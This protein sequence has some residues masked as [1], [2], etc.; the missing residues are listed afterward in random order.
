MGD[1]TALSELIKTQQPKIRTMLYYLKKDENDLNDLVQNV[2]IK[3]NTKIYQLKNPKYFRTWLNQI[4]VNCY[5]DYLR[6]IRRE[7]AVL[8][9]LK[10]KNEYEFDISDEKTN[11]QESILQNELNFVIKKS[12]DSLPAYYK[13]A[14]TLRE[15]QGLSYDDI[16]KIT[17]SSIGTVKS[18]IA[19]A[20]TLIKKR[21]KRYVAI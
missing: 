1:K 15:L 8:K 16:S 4:I 18:R 3:L 6:K 9:S 5:Y 17:Q 11:P 13:I 14:L 2:L 20:R 7:P 21:I 19:R 12:I 10:E